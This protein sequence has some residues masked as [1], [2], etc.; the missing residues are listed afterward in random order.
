MNTVQEKCGLKRSL[1]K[2]IEVVESDNLPL[3]CT[4]YI[5]NE[6]QSIKDVLSF[7]STTH[8]FR[9]YYYS[10]LFDKHLS[11][12]CDHIIT[13]INTL[14]DVS[15]AIV[16][17]PI[18]DHV[19]GLLKK[20]KITKLLAVLEDTLFLVFWAKGNIDSAF[21]VETVFLTNAN[22]SFNEDGKSAIDLTVD[23]VK[24]TSLIDFIQQ[25]PIFHPDLDVVYL[26][27]G[28]QYEKVDNRGEWQIA[29][30][31]CYVY[32]TKD[33]SK[34]ALKTFI[35]I[36]LPTTK[37]IYLKRSKHVSVHHEVPMISVMKRHYNNHKLLKLM[38]KSYDR[39]KSQS[40]LTAF[41]SD[42]NKKSTIL[43]LE[44]SEESS[45]SSDS[46]ETTSSSDEEFDS[47][48]DKSS[49]EE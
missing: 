7:I 36:L 10:N 30:N 35:E 22:H 23:D 24:L 28:G 16:F 14:S 21:N 1:S 6:A 27:T 47:D 25:I 42:N 12:R 40:L 44:G 39:V 4:H 9:S 38:G 26:T 37:F 48:D 32:N 19:F 18:T 34:M 45:L 5:V 8:D 46:D 29:L 41:W 3:E 43:R 11:A 20:K 49:E 31:K 17:V 2:D 33:A 15:R 13:L